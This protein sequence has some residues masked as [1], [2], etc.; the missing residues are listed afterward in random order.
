MN[1]TLKVIISAEV[2]KL[3]N[4]LSSAKKEIQDY[5][6]KTKEENAGFIESFNKAGEAGKKVIT[7][8]VGAFAAAGTALLGVSAATAEYRQN[9]AL[10]ATAFETAG[11]SA[12]AAKDTYNELYRV[13]GDDGQTTEAAQHLAKL[14]TDQKNLSEWT[15]ICQGVYATFGASLPIESLTEAANETA[16]TGSLTGALADALNWAGVNEEAFQAQLDACNTEAEREALIRETLNGLYSTAAENYEINN[17][18]ALK[19]NEANAK[20][21]DQLAKLGAAFSPIM[22]MLTELGTKILAMITPYIEDFAAKHLPTLQAVLEKVANA[23]GAVIGWVVDNWELISTI[24]TVI[25]AVAAAFTVLQTAVSLANTIMTVMSMN[26]I[27]L[28]ITALIAVIALCVTHWDDIKAAASAAWDWICSIWNKAAEWFGGIVD[29]I[30]NAFANIG[31]WFKN[32]FSGAWE[33]VQNA[34]SNTKEWFSEKWEGIK[35]AFA[36]TKQWFSDTFS[37][38]KEGATK[39][40][41]NIGTWAKDTWGKV[42]NGFKSADSWM[43]SKFGAAWDGVKNAFSPFV[44]YFKQCWETVKGIFSVVKNVLSGNFSEAWEAI[45]GIFSGWASFFTNLWNNVK[46]IFVNIGGSIG[47]AVK[48]AISTAVNKVLS[49]AVS[50]I[51]GFISGINFAI[52]VINAIPGVN[53]SKINKLSVP[54]MAKGGIVDS[55]TLALVGEQGKEAVMP[56]ENNLEWL[57]KL[58]AMLNERMGG[59]NQPIVIN[60]DGK[61]FGEIAVD[62]INGL[63]RQRGSIPLVIA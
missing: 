27:V 51:N 24:G 52:G 13:L 23:I 40:W 54:A 16:K 19:Q 61:R 37:K 36:T 17:A 11:G 56:L 62:S 39:A 4:G 47:N 60:V 59:G 44:N 7:G 45:K 18:A 20:M 30:K 1:E 5:V 53:I 14:T 46:N 28:A 38:A 41:S 26:P 2:D 48:G 12:A 15:K 33:G 9:Q 55:A 3:K 35:G 21:T 8:V 57:D 43:S 63:T 58:A 50:I 10:L 22:T 29:G 34:W 25:L 6:K 32:L 49:A 31:D 42:E